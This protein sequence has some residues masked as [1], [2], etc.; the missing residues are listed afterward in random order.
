MDRTVATGT[1]YT[2]QYHSPVSDTFE[3]L[4]TCPDE[5]LLFF[6]HEPYDYVL[7]SGKTFVQHVYDSHYEGVEQVEKFV[8]QWKSLKG[9]ID[10]QRYNETLARLEYQVGHAT[11]WR[12]AVCQWFFKMSG[13][14]DKLNR[15]ENN[16]N[17]IEAE[18]ME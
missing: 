7:H 15:V 8:K 12:D 2:A 16:P 11:V 6:H 14:P 9:K 1:G 13:I 18:S 10:E 17:R 4:K 3:S 5:L